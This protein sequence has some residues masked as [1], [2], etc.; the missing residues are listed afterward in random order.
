MRGEGWR[1]RFS[2]SSPSGDG[3]GVQ[4]QAGGG[5]WG[6]TSEFPLHHSLRERRRESRASLRPSPRCARGGLKVT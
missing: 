4:P 6:T 3:E 1:A 5:E 2:Y